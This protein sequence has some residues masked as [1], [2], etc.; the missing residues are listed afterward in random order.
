MVKHPINL[1]MKENK[2][3]K[4][5]IEQLEKKAEELENNWKRALA[6]YKNLEKRVEEDREN[7]VLFANEGLIK[8]LLP[9][10]DNL[11]KLAEHFNDKGADLIVKELRN[12]LQEF[13]V[14]E[15]KTDGSEFDPMKMEA[16]EM[17][18]GER[19]K[20]VETI[21]KGYMLKDKL[22]R[23]AVVKVGNGE[24]LNN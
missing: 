9:I 22:I 8:K 19:N 3:T 17:V 18:K 5:K 13:G 23:P 2:E 7:W 20:V 12:V 10:A 21:S 14:E 24:T 11:E 6:D 16:I 1:N 4:L 15:I